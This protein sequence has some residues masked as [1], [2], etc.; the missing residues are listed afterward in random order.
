MS[1]M[2]DFKTLEYSSLYQEF[3]FEQFYVEIDEAIS[4]TPTIS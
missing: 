3:S 2:F 1:D 4:L